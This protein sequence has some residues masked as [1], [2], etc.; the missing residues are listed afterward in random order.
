MGVAFQAQSAGPRR[1]HRR[2]QASC[3]LLTCFT[4]G[5]K[6]IH[7][8]HESLLALSRRDHDSGLT[9]GT[10]EV[11]LDPHFRSSYKI[12]FERPKRQRTTLVAEDIALQATTKTTQASW[13]KQTIVIQRVNRTASLPTRKILSKWQ[14]RWPR[15]EH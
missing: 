15:Y 13:L 11:S 7:Y 10:R 8:V 2:C 6:Q 5:E 1:T 12:E 4:A 14:L 9:S 3:T